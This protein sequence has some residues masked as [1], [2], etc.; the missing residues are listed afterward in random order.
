[1]SW[2]VSALPK[3]TRHKA[4]FW[5]LASRKLDSSADSHEETCVRVWG[6]GGGKPPGKPVFAFVCV[7]VCVCIQHED[8]G[9]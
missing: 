8:T 4:A 6:G 3:V 9:H 5:L 7:F 1:M 2:S